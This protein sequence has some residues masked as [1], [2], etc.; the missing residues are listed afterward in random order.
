MT[1]QG[2]AARTEVDPESDLIF[3]EVTDLRDVGSSDFRGAVRSPGRDREGPATSAC[4]DVG[5][6]QVVGQDQDDVGP[7]R[8]R[9]LVGCRRGAQPG[10]ESQGQ[11]EVDS[12]HD[13]LAR[14]G[15]SGRGRAPRRPRP[16]RSG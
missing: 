6:A 8:G 1:C 16:G 12:T 14:P 7:P 11:P 13:G 4:G 5:V 3:G 15:G 2:Y 10:G 9:R